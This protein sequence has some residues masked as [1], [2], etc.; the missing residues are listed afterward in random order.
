MHQTPTAIQILLFLVMGINN[1]LK[2]KNA[3]FRALLT[4]NPG[5]WHKREWMCLVYLAGHFS[6]FFAVQRSP[7]PAGQ[8]LV[9]V[10]TLKGLCIILHQRQEWPRRQARVR[11][12][13]QGPGGGRGKEAW[14][15]GGS[16]EPPLQQRGHSSI[17]WSG[18][19]LG[20]SMVWTRNEPYP[21]FFTE[22]MKYVTRVM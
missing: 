2:K 21:L 11:V 19:P 4:E 13:G 14:W 1:I 3:A 12:F 22:S 18:Q 15:R 20:V 8:I 17:M 6:D 5:S 16:A 7:K 9:S 10:H